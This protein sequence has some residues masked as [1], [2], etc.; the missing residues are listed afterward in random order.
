[1]SIKWLTETD[2]DA[3][4]RLRNDLVLVDP[5][6]AHRST[7]LLLLADHLRISLRGNRSCEWMLSYIIMA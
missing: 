7:Y 5:G 2:S 6:F 4:N 1:M 3:D